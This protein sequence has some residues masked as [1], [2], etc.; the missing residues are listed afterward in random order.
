MRVLIAAQS[1]KTHFLGMVPLTWAL[2][3]A[4]HDVLVAGQ[5]GLMDAVGSAGLTGVSVGS[6]YRMR[7][8]LERRGSN[9]PELDLSDTGPDA[10]EWGRLLKGHRDLVTWWLRVI[11]EPMIGDLVRLCREWRPDLVIWEPT[12]LAAPIAA[13]AVGAV[14]ARLLWS[15]D[16]LGTMR[17]HYLRVMAE[18]PPGE[19][20]DPLADWLGSHARRLGGEFTERMTRGYF[21]I[22]YIPGALRLPEPDP[23]RYEP[24][25]Y[26][27]MRYEPMRYVPYNGRSV[28]PDWL[29]TPPEHTRVCLTLGTSATERYGGFTFPLREV[30][31]GL[32][33]LD[34]EVIAT[35]PRAE[36]ER[37]GPL[38]PNVR[39]VEFAPLH[40]LL[41]TCDAVIDQGGSG[42][43]LTAVASG[44][45]QVVVP[46]A[47]MF[48]TRPLAERFQQLGAGRYVPP[49]RADG[50]SVTNAL[51]DVL[52]D[53]AHT[54]GTH[55]LRA[56]LE[57]APAPGRIASD[58]REITERHAARH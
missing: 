14:H 31:D 54:A 22:D 18:Q 6:D 53:P 4:G 3:T 48:D 24:M 51:R 8:L 39:P 43:F 57:S 9:G 35:L 33:D 32:G 21:T 47:R 27:P 50:A 23:V 41:P 28:L 25:R 58:L 29:R 7:K 20:E 2:R 17:S 11:N 10:L 1:E 52:D 42:T 30:L 36:S 49:E 38:P 19:R 55:R 46:H 34:A 12:A 13:E 5:P 37:L 45:P 44:V 16:L 56:Q 15:L 26:E 40:A